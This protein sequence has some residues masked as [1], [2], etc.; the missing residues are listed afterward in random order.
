MTAFVNDR[1][2][3]DVSIDL[4]HLRRSPKKHGTFTLNLSN[5]LRNAVLEDTGGIA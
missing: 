1:C 5:L 3:K 2:F 4:K